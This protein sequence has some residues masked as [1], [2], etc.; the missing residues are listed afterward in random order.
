MPPASS[1]P[2]LKHK[3]NRGDHREL[4]YDHTRAQETEQKRIRGQMSCAECTRLKIKCDKQIPCQSCRRRGCAALCPNRSLSTG[5]GTRSVLAATEPL[6]HRIARLNE[7]IQQLEGAL[8]ELQALH[9]VGPHPLLRPDALG[10]PRPEDGARAPSSDPVIVEHPPDFVEAMGTLSVS[11]SGASRFFGPTAG[12]HCLLMIDD[13]PSE[14]FTNGSCSKSPEVL[15]EIENLT[16]AFPFKPVHSTLS[17]ESLV[18]SYLPTWERALYLTEAYVE[19][20]TPLFQSVSRDHIVDELLPAYYVHGV[21]HV[22]QVENPHQLG[23][24]FVIFATAALLDP[25][26]E[27]K[28][29]GVEAESYHKAARAAI[30]L[31]SVMQK[32]SL[33]TIQVLHLLS[34]CNAVSGNELAGKETSMET[35]WSLVVLAAHLAHTVNRDGLRWGMPAD[36]TARRRMIF[37]DLFVADIWNCLEAGRPPTFSLPYID[38]QFPGGGSP[39]DKAHISAD[40]QEFCRSWAFRF[41]SSC[42]ADVAALALASD[43]PSYPTIL[44][45]DR[46]VRDFPVT[47]AAEYFAAAA[48]DAVPAK[49][50]DSDIGLMDSMIRFVMSNAREIRGYFVQAVIENPINPLGSPYTPSF[51]AAYRASLIILR[52]VEVQYDLH[53]KPIARLSPMWMSAFSAAVVFGAIVIRGPRSPMASSAMKELRDACLLFSKVSSHSRKAQKALPIITR[54]TEKAHNALF[55]AQS[56]MPYEL[57]QQWCIAD[58][59]G[60]KDVAIFAGGMKILPMK[61]HTTSGMLNSPALV[62]RHKQ[63]QLDPVVLQPYNGEELGSAFLQQCGSA[64]TLEPAQGV[65]NLERTPYPD[66]SSQSTALLP[67]PHVPTQAHPQGF[68]LSHN[69]Y[70][71]HEHCPP[72]SSASPTVSYYNDQFPSAGMYHHQSPPPSHPSTNSHPHSPPHLRYPIQPPPWQHQSTHSDPPQSQVV[73]LAPPEL[74]LAAQESV[75]DQRW[76]SFMRESGFLDG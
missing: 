13:A 57:G 36:I 48:C 9:F 30:C 40:R 75:L 63:N 58:D 2:N 38:C 4:E 32:P 17:V 7:R 53:P 35:S 28:S 33:E 55:H 51:L 10:A 14:D 27:P 23:L 19:Q 61:R 49:P 52:T 20:T 67:M 18:N 42:V 22:A 37:W 41:A 6:Y 60:D 39:N 26:Q 64:A 71:Q 62:S 70:D 29:A 68:H 43:S 21:P 47:E 54:L 65:P 3:P 1:I 5:L 15:Q 11:G 31:R 46:Q 12:S 69:R 66:T 44:E 56:D 8:S 76:V 16:A 72:T 25:N 45:L 34:V 59:E 74:C 73:P 50:A 24:L